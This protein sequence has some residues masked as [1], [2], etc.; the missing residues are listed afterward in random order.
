MSTLVSMN[1]VGDRVTAS[2][3]D[4]PLGSPY[5]RLQVAVNGHQVF[6]WD[7]SWTTVQLLHTRLGQLL[8]DRDERCQFVWDSGNVCGVQKSLH[9]AQIGSHRFVAADPSA[10]AEP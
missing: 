8:L 7:L 3:S 1:T 10:S 6:A 9:Q 4:A 2:I 5:S